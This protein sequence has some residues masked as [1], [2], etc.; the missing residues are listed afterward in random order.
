MLDVSKN[1]SHTHYFEYL[2]FLKS[3]TGTQVREI[4]RS[5]YSLKRRSMSCVLLYSVPLCRLQ[6]IKPIFLPIF[7]AKSNDQA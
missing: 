3:N 4:S 2:Y 7:H 1:N 6:Q 5:K